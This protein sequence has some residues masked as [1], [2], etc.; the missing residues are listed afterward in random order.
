MKVVAGLLTH[1]EA[2]R[3][4]DLVAAQLASVAHVVVVDDASTDSTPYILRDL[5]IDSQITVHQNTERVFFKHEGRCRQHLMNMVLAESP[6]AI[7]AIDADEL[8]SNPLAVTA[9]VDAMTPGV[10]HAWSLPMQE[11]WKADDNALWVRSD[12]GWKQHHVPVLY[13][14]PPDAHTM[15]R[16]NDKALACGRQPQIINQLALA[17][18][19]TPIPC[20]ILHFGWTRESE[21]RQRWERYATHDGGRFHAN[22]H[23]QSIMYPDRKVRLTRRD[24]PD[25][26]L[27]IKQQILER[28][29]R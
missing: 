13:S 3:Y 19:A 24:W 14:V 26:L 23:I 9:A 2:D 7:L 15:F 20:E 17:R 6:D 5:A 12:G 29:N 8:L 28:V 21:R 22:Q 25:A 16:I 27:P 10:L 4:V 11:I 18:K 1:N